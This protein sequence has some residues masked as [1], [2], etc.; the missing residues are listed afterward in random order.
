MKGVGKCVVFGGR[1]KQNTLYPI[2][3]FITVLIHGKNDCKK[4]GVRNSDDLVFKK[5][6]I[7]YRLPNKLKGLARQIFAALT[8]YVFGCN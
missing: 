3:S 6:V 8:S 7:V 2:L 1:S 5:P 4:L